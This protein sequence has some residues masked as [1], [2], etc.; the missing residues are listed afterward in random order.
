MFFPFGL[1][2]SLKWRKSEY[3]EGPFVCVCES[4]RV[5]RVSTA[6]LVWSITVFHKELRQAIACKKTVKLG[7]WSL[8]VSL[9][10]CFSLVLLKL[11]VSFVAL[12]DRT[13]FVVSS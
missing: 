10:R 12:P 9:V 7:C 13:F 5:T 1:L 3:E 6:N 2:R 11:I 4:L 8:L